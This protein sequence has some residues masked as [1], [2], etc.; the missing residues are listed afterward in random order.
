MPRW[1]GVW[2]FIDG[3]ANVNLSMT[4]VLFPQWQGKVFLYSQPAL[5]GELA[6]LLW[7]LI[8][9]ATPAELET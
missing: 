2:L 8:K 5:F 1:L 3:L 4:G 6:L 7:L 9:G